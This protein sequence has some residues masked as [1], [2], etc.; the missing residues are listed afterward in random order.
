MANGAVAAN[1]PSAPMAKDFLA[2][3]LELPA[4]PSAAAALEAALADDARLEA[5]AAAGH[6]ACLAGHLW[7][8]RAAEIL[9]LAAV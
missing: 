4:E 9:R 8:H 7:E 6:K 3:F 2:G 1:G 5:I